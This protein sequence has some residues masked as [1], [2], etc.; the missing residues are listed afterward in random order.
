MRM[1][2]WVLRKEKS[3]D[4]GFVEPD[5]GKLERARKTSEDV[6]FLLSQVCCLVDRGEADNRKHGGLRLAELAGWCGAG[7]QLSQQ[8]KGN[9]RAPV[10]S[11]S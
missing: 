8:E 10:A 11:S 9:E 7:P 5:S 1:A 6:R 4:L 3:A 2:G